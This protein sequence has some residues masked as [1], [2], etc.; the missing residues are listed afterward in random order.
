MW[1][2]ELTIKPLYTVYKATKQWKAVRKEISERKVAVIEITNYSTTTH[3]PTRWTVG[4]T[5]IRRSVSGTGS[6]KHA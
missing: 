2:N 1:P 6:P 5:F 4:I 3:L